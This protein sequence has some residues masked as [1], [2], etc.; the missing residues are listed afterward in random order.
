[1]HWY[2]T[3]AAQGFAK[4]TVPITLPAGTYTFEASAQGMSGDLVFV[5]ILNGQDEV[6]FAGEAAAMAGWVNWQT[7]KVTFT[8]ESETDV[9]LR[10]DV[11]MQKGGWGTVDC[12]R[13]YR[14]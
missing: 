5:S 3:Q 13:L 12:L 14:H 2:L 4:Y 6:L 11:N 8:L 7:P 1:M 10:I 9:Y